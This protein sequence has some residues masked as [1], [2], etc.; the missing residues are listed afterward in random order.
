MATILDICN[1]MLLDVGADV[2]TTIASNRQGM[3]ASRCFRDAVIDVCSHHHWPWMKRIISADS[4]VNEVATLNPNAVEFTMVRVG[5][6]P[7]QYIND[8]DF[9]GG[10]HLLSSYTTDE[11]TS[12]YPAYYTRT[13][14]RTFAVNPYPTTPT[15]QANVQFH[16]RLLPTITLTDDSEPDIP[17]DVLRL[18]RYYASA[19][20]AMKLTG[21]SNLSNRYM[22]LY[23]QNLTQTRA[24]YTFEN[25]ENQDAIA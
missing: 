7:F 17:A 22:D 21:E 12:L 11:P 6:F 18:V 3:I 15:G 13:G 1:D 25:Q 5:T 24:R 4:W 2:V 14:H 16:V 9:Y 19:T 10:H 23:Q 20:L 8:H